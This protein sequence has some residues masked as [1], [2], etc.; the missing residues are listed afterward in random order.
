MVRV[1]FPGEILKFLFSS[2]GP[3]WLWAHLASSPM[4]GF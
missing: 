1:E 4:A 3:E 2:T